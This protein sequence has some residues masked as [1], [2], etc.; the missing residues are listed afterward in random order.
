MRKQNGDTKI[1]KI[2]KEKLNK[3]I[4]KML[5][6]SIYDS[7]CQKCYQSTRYRLPNADGDVQQIQCPIC[8]YTCQAWKVGEWQ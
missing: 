1:N 2:Q 6:F 7:K 8:G 3:A 5:G 4:N